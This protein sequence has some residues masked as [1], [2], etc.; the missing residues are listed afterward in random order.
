MGRIFMR[1]ED[2][3][4]IDFSSYIKLGVVLW[5]Y[6]FSGRWGEGIGVF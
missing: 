4:V 3:R 2:F 6:V 1:K 5:V